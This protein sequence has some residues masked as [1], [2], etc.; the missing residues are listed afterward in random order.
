MF[1]SHPKSLSNILLVIAWLSRTRLAL[2]IASDGAAGRK[3]TVKLVVRKVSSD[4][5][6]Y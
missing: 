4:N 1:L 2:A 6:A 3:R 5:V